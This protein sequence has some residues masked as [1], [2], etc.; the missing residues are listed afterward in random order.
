MYSL[1]ERVFILEHYFVSKLF[2]AVREKLTNGYRDK[3]VPYKTTHRLVT[4]FQDT[5]SVCL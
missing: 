4:V 2:A 3:E 5:D 1:E